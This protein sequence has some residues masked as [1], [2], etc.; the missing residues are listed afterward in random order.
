MIVDSSTFDPFHKAMTRF[1]FIAIILTIQ[2]GCMNPVKN[3]LPVTSVKLTKHLKSGMHYATSPFIPGRPYL[4][5]VHG[6][7]GDWKAF[8]DYIADP[9]LQERFN[10]VA[11]D[12]LGFGS[13]F[14]RKPVTTFKEH[15]RAILTF[16]EDVFPNVRFSCVGHS[17]GGPLCLNLMH[18][19]PSTFQDS[20][21]VA[22]V[23]NPH[24][25]ILRWYNTVAKWRLVKPLLPLALKNSNKEMDALKGELYDLEK[26]IPQITQ[27]VNLIH[28]E[29]D[30][31]VPVGDSDWLS[32]Q[33]NPRSMGEYV[34]PKEEGHFVLWKQMDFIKQKIIEHL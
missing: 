10:M 32:K 20:L 3:D 9:K 34:R 7:P 31:I 22:G 5:F 14:A 18:W 21:L 8:Q 24:R 25:K 23:Y 11:I 2:L 13:S 1:G 19:Q 27:K 30:K 28:G 15:S 12:R 29:K 33:L 17:Y 6:T 4:L 16:L 26:K